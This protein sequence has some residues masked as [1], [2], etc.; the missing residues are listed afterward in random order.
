MLARPRQTVV[1]YMGLNGL[2]IICSRMMAHGLPAD[3]P[4]AVV[5]QASTPQQREVIATLAT[6]PQAVAAAGLRSPALI[7]IGNVVGLHGQLHWLNRRAAV[8]A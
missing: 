8:T 7:V 6:L 1:I 5:Q 3:T 2:P 4:A